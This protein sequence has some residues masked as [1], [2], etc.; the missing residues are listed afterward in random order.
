MNFFSIRLL[1]QHKLTCLW[2]W[3]FTQ[4][5]WI[6]LDVDLVCNNFYNTRFWDSSRNN[7]GRR[8]ERA[9]GYKTL[10]LQKRHTLLSLKSLIKTCLEFLLYTRSK[11]L[12]PTCLLGLGWFNNFAENYWFTRFDRSNL[13]FDRSILVDFK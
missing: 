2:L 7:I 3:D 12:N 8:H 9:F 13:T 6:S 1:Q 10:N 4:R 5:F 11:I